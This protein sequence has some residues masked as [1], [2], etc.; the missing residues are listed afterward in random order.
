MFIRKVRNRRL[1]LEFLAKEQSINNNVYCKFLDLSSLRE[2]EDDFSE[3]DE[4]A[5]K[6]LIIKAF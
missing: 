5:E 1:S 3:S 2:R 4:E 6:M